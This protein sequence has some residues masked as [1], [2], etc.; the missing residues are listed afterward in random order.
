MG[1][2]VQE[3]PTWVWLL[4]DPD[5]NVATEVLDDGAVASQRAYDPYGAPEGGGTSKLDG[6]DKSDLGFQSDYTDGS[7]GNVVMGPRLYDP[8]TARFTTADFYVGSDADAGLATDPLTGNRYLFAAANPVAYFD[9]GHSPVCDGAGC[10]NQGDDKGGG[11][12]RAAPGNI[13][14]AELASSSLGPPTPPGMATTPTYD[15]IEDHTY[16]GMWESPWWPFFR[17][18]ADHFVLRRGRPG[19]HWNNHQYRLEWDS[20]KRK[21]HFNDNVKYPRNSPQA[22]QPFLNGLWHGL[23]GLA[24]EVMIIPGAIPIETF[25]SGD[26]ITNPEFCPGEQGFPP[27]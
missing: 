6:H 1:D 27:S 7:T 3:A 9:D 5:G 2:P 20:V 13:P 16:A 21:W 26:D 4:R 18:E 14:T 19:F 15:A 23:G 22:H 24:G 10:G 17:K 25:C 8:A 12:T 11:S